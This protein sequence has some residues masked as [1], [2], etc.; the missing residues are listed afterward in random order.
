MKEAQVP[1]LNPLNAK[2]IPTVLA[3]EFL[4][5]SVRCLMRKGLWVMS[6]W[7]YGV[8]GLLGSFRQ[9]MVRGS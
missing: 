5:K 8:M 1:K 7:A 6:L 2:I 3:E 9:S 4:K